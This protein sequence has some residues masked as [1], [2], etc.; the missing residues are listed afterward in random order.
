[1][2]KFIMGAIVGASLMLAG[3]VFADEIQSMV[4]KKVEG[5]FPLYVNGERASKDVLVIEGTSYGPVRLI[6]E[7]LGYDVSFIDSEVILTKK[8]PEVDQAKMVSD[9]LE[10]LKR[11][12]KIEATEEKAKEILQ[13]MQEFGKTGPNVSAEM[14]VN[15]YYKW[16]GLD[17]QQSE[18]II[19]ELQKQYEDEVKAIEDEKKRKLEEERKFQESLQGTDESR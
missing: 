2:K 9:I 14:L 5:S 7:M 4:G 1:M 16:I 17:K 11:D 8:N 3:T 6:A 15:A 19:E 10:I 12:G 18:K 13:K